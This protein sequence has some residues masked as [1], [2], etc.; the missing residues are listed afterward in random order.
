[1]C[2][3]YNLFRYCALTLISWALQEPSSQITPMTNFQSARDK[4]QDTA[5]LIARKL[6]EGIA[7]CANL[8]NWENEKFYSR[9]LTLVNSKLP[10]Q[11]NNVAHEASRYYHL[12][13]VKLRRS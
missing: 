12:Y 9:R 11:I 7:E 5:K 8:P 3:I 1:M 10:I 2:K 4:Y 6:Q 13:Q